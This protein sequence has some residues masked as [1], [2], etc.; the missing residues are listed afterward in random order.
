[1]P[2]PSG[3]SNVQIILHWTIAALVIFQ[4][5]FN[6]GM[7]AAFNDHLEGRAV[8]EMNAAIL[9]M[10]VGTA[11]LVLACIRLAIRRVRGVPVAHADNPAII[12]WIGH[13]AHIMLYGFIFFMPLSGLIAW[14]GGVEF[15]AELHELGRLVL[16]PVIGLHVLGAFA[17]HLVFHNDSLRRMLDFNRD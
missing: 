12:N 10:V 8:D 6:T 15:S 2:A 16:I 5:F 13:A 11:V 1:M 7:Q 17:E 14:F 9:H 3:Y 4:L